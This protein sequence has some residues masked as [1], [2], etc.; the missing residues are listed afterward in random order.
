VKALSDGIK[1]ED[2]RRAAQQKDGGT[3]GSENG[4]TGGSENGGTGGGNADPANGLWSPSFKGPSVARKVYNALP[5]DSDFRPVLV[6]MGAQKDA[7]APVEQAAKL[8]AALKTNAKVGRMMVTLCWMYGFR[9][10]VGMTGFGM[11]LLDEALAV[12]DKAAAAK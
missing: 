4:G 12:L 11:P 3:G 8:E 7:I 2:G 5:K 1:R 9:A 10:P 6:Y